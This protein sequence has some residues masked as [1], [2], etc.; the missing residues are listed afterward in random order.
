MIYHEKEKE[1]KVVN[2]NR[3][4]LIKDVLRLISLNNMKCVPKINPL[5]ASP[6][7]QSCSLTITFPSISSIPLL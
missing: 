2:K 6:L 4:S 1:K 7:P 5:I 3:I